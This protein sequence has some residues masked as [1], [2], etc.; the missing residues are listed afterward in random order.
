MMRMR[1]KAPGSD[2]KQTQND[3]EK[4][5]KLR[6]KIKATSD[7]DEVTSIGTTSTMIGLMTK[8]W[9]SISTEMGGKRSIPV[10]L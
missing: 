6:R 8:S 5:K 3:Q 7:A 10:S 2:E 9:T 4:R 1:I